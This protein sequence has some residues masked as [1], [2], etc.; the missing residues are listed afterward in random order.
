MMGSAAESARR[1]DARS[2]EGLVEISE[3]RAY[4]SLIEGAPEALRRSFG[5]QA[6]QLGVGCALIAGGFA[7]TLVLNRVLGLGLSE[8][9]TVAD[10]DLLDSFYVAS[11]VASYAIELSPSALPSNLA[12]VLC[13][14]GFVPFKQTSMMLRSCEPIEPS[15]SALRVRR[16]HAH[17][18]EAFAAL[19]CRVFGYAEPMPQILRATFDSAKWQQWMAFERDIPVAAAITHLHDSTAWIGWVCTLPGHRGK[20]AQSA[21]AAAQLR[22]AAE[23]GL[24]WVTLEAAKG[25]KTQ[26]GQSL[27]NYRRL[28]WTTVHDRV[29]YVRRPQQ[30]P[31]SH[32]NPA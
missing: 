15:H 29:I 23:A 30:A 1:W 20:G 27:R 17:E 10:L 22:A 3:A 11:G 19:C 28:G 14:R 25:S 5:L 7:H 18:A 8:P 31:L 9:A 24:R 32:R 2:A 16:V 6:Q 13:N 4:S 26:P 12:D 21:L